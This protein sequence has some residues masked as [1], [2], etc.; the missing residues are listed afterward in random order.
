MGPIRVGLRGGVC[1]VR[2]VCKSGDGDGGPQSLEIMFFY[3]P[4]VLLLKSL[5]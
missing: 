3:R 5:C 1:A 4:L 2:N